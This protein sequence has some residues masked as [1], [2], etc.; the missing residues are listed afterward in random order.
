VWTALI[1]TACLLMLPGAMVCQAFFKLLSPIF[2]LFLDVP[3]CLCPFCHRCTEKKKRRKYFVFFDERFI[4][5]QKERE[6]KR[7]RS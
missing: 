2:P 5:C 6:E 4:C 3:I 7:E 1:W